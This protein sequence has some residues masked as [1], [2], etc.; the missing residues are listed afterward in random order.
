MKRK[1]SRRDFL[2]GKSAAEAMTDT[3]QDALSD[4]DSQRPANR[5]AG[6]SYLVHVTR[7]AMACDF[8]ISLNAGQYERDTELALEALDLVD[9]LE[10]Q[11]SVFRETS[12]IC[13]VNRTAAGQ[14]VEVEGELFELLRLAIRVHGETDG[15]FDVTSAPLWEVWGFARR[16]GAIPDRQQL[17]EALKHVGSHLVELD[18]E[19]K[20]VRFVQPGVQLN[21]GGIGKGH[22]LDRGAEKLLQAGIGDFLMH[23]GGSSVL[24]RGSQ[25]TMP[26]E[27][28]AGPSGGWTVGIR[29]PLRPTGDWPKSAFATGPWRPRAPGPSRSYTRAAVGGTSSIHAPA[30]R[31]KES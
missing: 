2:K 5:A 7:R 16:A 22:A 28:P 31:P 23:G 15:A 13:H 30:G 20:T 11:M 3:L 4:V 9:A 26:G 21:L 29:H 14:P 25:A 12:E 8:Q 19:R 17:A 1:T 6:K 27:S 10:D 24:A 18:P